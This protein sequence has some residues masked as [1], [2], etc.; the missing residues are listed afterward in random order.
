[1]RPTVYGLELDFQTRCSHWNGL[2]D[3]IAIKM[4]CCAT[5]YAC[6]QC[7]DASEQHPVLVW[8]QDEWNESAVLCGACRQELTV[9][10][11]LACGS[12]CPRCGA[13]FNP[14]CQKHH[15]LYFAAI[16]ATC[17]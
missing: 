2:L 14:G 11:Y 12:H 13:G 15:H 4:R 3:I 16:E 5:Y 9:N 8:P 1:M 6:R 7:H 17:S 10:A